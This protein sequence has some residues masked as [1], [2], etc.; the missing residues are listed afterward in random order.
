[1]TP[2]ELYDLCLN[3]LEN[4]LSQ[5]AVVLKMPG[6]W[7]NKV[8]RTLAGNGSPVGRILGDY[9]GPTGGIVVEFRADEVIAWLEKKVGN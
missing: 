4:P 2:Q 8:T 3:K 5:G 7:G 9:F 1:M 6:K